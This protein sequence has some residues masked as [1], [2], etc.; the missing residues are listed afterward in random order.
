[1][2]TSTKKR[3]LKQNRDILDSIKSKTKE[4]IQNRK[5]VN[6]IIDIQLCLEVIKQIYLRLNF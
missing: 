2:A 5:K 4:I 1:M 3:D 6:H